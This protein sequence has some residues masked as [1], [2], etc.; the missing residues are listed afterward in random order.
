MP[1]DIIPAGEFKTHC[2]QIMETVRKTGKKI[3]I[4][5]RNVPIAQIAPIE[6]KQQQGFGKLKGSVHIE[7][8]IIDPI[9]ENWY[10]D[11]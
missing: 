1:S 4:T 9:H 2:L 8:N 3:T 7:M 11:S 10:A 6:K 5:K